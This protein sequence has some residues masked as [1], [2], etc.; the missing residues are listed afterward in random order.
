VIG[1]LGHFALILAFGMAALQL[2][3]PLAGIKLGDASLMVLARPAALAQFLLVGLSFA[4]LTWGYLASDFSILNVAQNSHTLKPWLYKLTGVWG[5]HEGS[6]L[7]WV[8]ILTLF[9]ASVALIG[10]DLTLALKARVLSVQAF[11]ALGF[12]AFILFTSNPFLRLDPAPLQ[13]RGL[14]PLL[15]DP[16]LA[17]HPPL[18]YLGYV[19]FSIAFSFAIAA[20]IEGRIDALW[21]RL[22]RPWTLAAWAFLTG[23]IAL[24]SWWAYYELGWGGWWFWDPVENASF[25]PWLM[26]TAL[27]HGIAVVEKRESLK[28]W[29]ILLAIL[30]FGLSLLGTF[31]VRSGV[32][33][34]VHAFASDPAR[35]VFILSF[36]VL[37]VGGS[38]ILF[39]L[40]APNL[41]PGGFFRPLSREGGIVF[42]NLLLSA[43]AAT[44]FLG[45]LYPL[46]LDA[47][48]GEKVSVGPPYYHATFVPLMAPLVAVMAVGPLLPWKRADLASVLARLKFAA[49]VSLAVALSAWW[50]ATDGPLLAV[51]G[52]FLAAWLGLSALTELWQRLGAKAALGGAFF[53][54]A[55][56]LPRA[57]YGMTLA[58]FGMAVTIMGITVSSAFSAGREEIV[59]LGQPVEVGPVRYTFQ[60]VRESQGPNYRA[61]SGLFEVAMPSGETLR[62]VPETRRYPEPPMETTE[63]AIRPS[64][65]ADLYA[66]IG[67]AQGDGRAARLYYKPFVSWIWLGGLMM[68]AGG[69]L[70]MTDRRNRIEAEAKS[71]AARTDEAHSHRPVAKE[72]V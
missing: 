33:N 22:V 13:G 15:Q 60:G 44:V 25:M 51:L 12:M 55:R 56:G 14:N 50:F 18:L 21:A 46:F 2:V 7:L 34:S 1:E 5:N 53:V 62:L 30:T 4:C 59:R 8:L 10:R 72:L 32:L 67:E 29:T 70:S 64:L 16:G 38:L 26:G 68:M 45:T 71:R 9:G 54:R 66:V 48:T 6:M 57:A 20:L 35:G 31:L 63:A 69:L 43:A 61:I 47:V 37:T 36:L 42:N 11:V 28:S 40:R 23:G 27:V 41:K 19:G 49:F 39:A 3:L 17:F 65:L 58:H 52:M 24:G